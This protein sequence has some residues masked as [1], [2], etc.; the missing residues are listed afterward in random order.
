MRRA[1]STFGKRSLCVVMQHADTIDRYGRYSGH[2][3]VERK[4]TIEELTRCDPERDSGQ[5]KASR[6]APICIHFAQ[7]KCIGVCEM[8]PRFCVC[9]CVC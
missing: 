8:N 1:I 7:G 2:D 5:T 3:N 4:P 6:T 9:V